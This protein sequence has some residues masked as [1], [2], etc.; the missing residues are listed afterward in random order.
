MSSDPRI[1]KARSLIKNGEFKEARK[2]LNQFKYNFE[3]K[4]LLKY[5]EQH[6]AKKQRP[7]RQAPQ[8]HMPSIAMPSLGGQVMIL[9]KEAPALPFYFVMLSIALCYILFGALWIRTG[10]NPLL[11][12][13]TVALTGLLSMLMLILQWRYFWWLLAIQILLSLVFI[14]WAFTAG[15]TLIT[16]L[17]SRPTVQSGYNIDE[18]L[19]EQNRLFDLFYGQ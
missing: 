5:I 9:G 6:E 19:E 2:I 15:D 7:P 3:A 8:I 11:A 18:L 10:A 12:I 13:P 14:G 4:D 16:Q 17:L 1:D